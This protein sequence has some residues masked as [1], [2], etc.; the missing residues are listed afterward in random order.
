MLRNDGGRRGMRESEDRDAP[1][2]RFFVPVAA[3]CDTAI[4][5]K[6]DNTISLIRVIDRIT[7]RYQLR[8]G[9]PPADQREFPVQVYAVFIIHSIDFA[10]TKP[11]RIVAENPEDQVFA[12]LQNEIEFTGPGPVRGVNLSVRM[13]LA[14]QMSGVHWLKAYLDD[15]ELAAAPLTINL[16]QQEQQ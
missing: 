5:D 2:P 1:H 8:P 6:V 4:V 10:G 11:F 7:I 15:V 16:Q 9:D 3:V 13:N 14:V 12:E